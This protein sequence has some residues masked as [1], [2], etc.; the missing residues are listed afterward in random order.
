MVSDA[1]TALASA[2]A[3]LLDA[4]EMVRASLLQQ[5]LCTRKLFESRQLVF[6]LTGRAEY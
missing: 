4:D 2:E 3:A 6:D 5:E 1:L